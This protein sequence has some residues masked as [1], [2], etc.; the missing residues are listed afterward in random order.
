MTDIL[1]TT[2]LQKQYE[3]GA[4]I[5]D[6]LRGVNFSVSQGEFVAIMGP[7]GSGKS[8]LLHLLGGLDNPTDGEITLEKRRMA[9]LSDDEITIIRRRQVGFI[10]QF[11]NLFNLGQKPAIHLGI[12]MH[13]IYG[14]V[15]A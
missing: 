10:F 12:F 7:S 4:V 9:H 15:A 14:H 13:F 8:T 6:A 3:M 5:V 1:M 11:Y 2:D